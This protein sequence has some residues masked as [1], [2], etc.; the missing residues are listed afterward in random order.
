MKQ[1]IFATIVFFTVIVIMIICFINFLDNK[2]YPVYFEED[3]ISSANEFEIE[4]Y[5]IASLINVESSFKQFAQSKKGA[6][7]LMQL[8]P[9]TAEWI[10]PKV[11]LKNF[12]NCMLTSP[13]INIRLGTYYLRYLFDKFNNYETALCAYNAGEGTVMFWLS[14]NEYSNDGKKVTN[15][16]FKETKNYLEKLEKNIEKYKKKF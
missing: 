3:I 4:P 7:G 5:L 14:K 9:S 2:F 11:G 6:V 1:K 16:P 15:I 8:L 10:A 13:S 12:E